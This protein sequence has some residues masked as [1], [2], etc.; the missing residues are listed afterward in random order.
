MK[1]RFELRITTNGVE[2]DVFMWGK[3][4]SHWKDHITKRKRGKEEEEEEE[5]DPA[6]K[7]N[8]EIWHDVIHD[9]VALDNKLLVIS[10]YDNVFDI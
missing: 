6:S 1:Q 5:E 10:L 2:H 4:H 9:Y 7:V 8:F 3:V